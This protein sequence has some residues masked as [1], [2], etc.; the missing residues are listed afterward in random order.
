[1]P[2]TLVVAELTY[3]SETVSARGRTVLF[4]EWAQFTLPAVTDVTILDLVMPGDSSSD[5]AAGESL[6]PSTAQGM[7]FVPPSLG[8]ARGSI[9]VS[10]ASS[11]GSMFLGA[12]TRMTVNPDTADI[13]YEVEWVSPVDD[14]V[15]TYGLSVGGAS[16]YVRSTDLPGG[17]SVNFLDPP[18]VNSPLSMSADIVVSHV[19]PGADVRLNIVRDDLSTGWRVFQPGGSATMHIPKL[20]SAIDPRLVLGTGEV[21]VVPQVCV[22]GPDGF[23]AQYA[24]GA[25]ATLVM[26]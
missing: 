19:A 2:L 25:P 13:D 20:P 15:T 11:S 3:G 6:M 16:S 8:G 17:G 23:C 1:L 10:N 18:S 24:T 9:F 21:T 14:L 26:P 4:K 12:A 7:L 5:G 22:A